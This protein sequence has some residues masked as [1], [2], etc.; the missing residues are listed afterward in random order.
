MIFLVIKEI[1]KHMN[2]INFCE[3]LPVVLS[4]KLRH[5]AQ[6]QDHLKRVSVSATF[7]HFPPQSYF[8]K[9][10]C[11]PGGPGEAISSPIINTLYALTE[12]RALS[13]PNPPIPRFDNSTIPHFN[14]QP[15]KLP[16]SLDLPTTSLLYYPTRL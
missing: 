10:H 7:I 12:L 15:I 9:R 6:V 14:N 2:P 16:F 13:I 3:G 8:P 1:S 11:D 5:G 4:A